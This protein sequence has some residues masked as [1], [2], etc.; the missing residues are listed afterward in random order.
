MARRT[1]CLTVCFLFVFLSGCFVALA[2]AP[3][4]F[5]SV[6]NWSHFRL[7][8]RS[9][10]WLDFHW[11][12]TSVSQLVALGRRTRHGIMKWNFFFLNRYGW[13]SDWAMDSLIPVYRT[14]NVHTRQ[15]IILMTLVTVIEILMTCW[16]GRNAFFC[17]T[18]PEMWC[19]SASP[20]SPPPFPFP[21]P[22]P[23]FV[24]VLVQVDL[25]ITLNTTDTKMGFFFF[26]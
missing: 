6:L 16:W 23:P 1:H 26:F 14:N 12:R 13:A 9:S 3:V 8:W 20:L 21:P 25:R 10:V 4:S 11:L 17:R 7:C 22:P 24:G 5:V 18:G 19:K 2:S 15:F